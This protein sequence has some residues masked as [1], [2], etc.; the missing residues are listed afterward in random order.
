MKP[1]NLVLLL[2]LT[3]ATSGLAVAQEREAVPAR[4]PALGAYRMTAPDGKTVFPFQFISNHVVIPVELNGDT[5]RLILDTGMPVDGAL[6]FGSERVEKLGLQYVGKAPVTGVGG[7]KTESDV[8]MGVTFRVPGAEFTNQ[9]VLVMPPDSVRGGRFERVNGVIGQTLFGHLVVGID[10]DRKVVTLTEPSRFEYTGS[11][12]ELPLRF[13]RYPLLACSLA[14]S[15]EEEVGVD[16]VVDTGNV[17]ALT[18]NPGAKEGV[19][20]PVNTIDCRVAGLGRDIP[21][22]AGRVERLRLGPY[23]L[24]NLLASFRDSTSEA[25]PPWETIGALGQGVFKRFNTIF[26]Y[27]HNRIILEPSS[28]FDE[29]FEFNMAGIQFIRGSGGGFQITHV[30]KG[31]PASEAGLHVDDCIVQ[32]DGEPA[33]R[34]SADELERLLTKEGADVTLNLQR[35]GKPLNVRLRLRRLV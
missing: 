35:T 7:D 32:I 9:M 27:A 33:S 12:W 13:G 26:D 22:L 16:L 28:R 23:T 15:G 14:V 34:L 31:S 4:V 3:L 2:V 10:H 1:H 21:R 30:V 6:L 11:G 20:L 19:V 17:N 29:P 8:A 24:K 18:L 5:L 25:A